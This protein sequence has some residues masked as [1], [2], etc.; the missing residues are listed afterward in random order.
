M[1]DST[2]GCPD[3][4]LLSHLPLLHVLPVLPC[5]A[6]GICLTP[7]QEPV[8]VAASVRKWFSFPGCSCKAASRTDQQ[9]ATQIGRPCSQF[10]H[11]YHF[12]ILPTEFDGIFPDTVK[13]TKEE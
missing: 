6:A 4:V 7:Q 10:L 2:L 1:G 9:A 5:A 11:S 3:P 12:F 8:W 13:H